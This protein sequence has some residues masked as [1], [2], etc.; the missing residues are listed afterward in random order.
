MTRL[1]MGIYEHVTDAS[2]A[3]V[4]LKAGGIKEKDISVVTKHEKVV[5]RIC[6]DTGIGKSDSGVG[7]GGL[8]GLGRRIGVGLDLLPDTAV[9]AGPAARK[10]AGAELDKDSLEDGLVVSLIG[11]GIPEQDAK[12]YA[13]HANQEKIIVIVAIQNKEEKEIIT[14]LNSHNVIPL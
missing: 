14:I 11:I 9:A 13:R 3:I 6:Q 12:G 2:L 8:F 4:D 7:L 10:L 1:I 5:D